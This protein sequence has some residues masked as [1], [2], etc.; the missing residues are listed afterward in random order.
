MS[1]EDKRKLRRRARRAQQNGYQEVCGFLAVGR[2]RTLPLVF[3]PNRA[4]KAGSFRIGSAD[5]QRVRK[6]LGKTRIVGTFHSHP[7]SPPAPSDSDIARARIGHYLMIHDVCGRVTLLWRIGR[8][9]GKKSANEIELRSTQ[10]TK[11]P[12]TPGLALKRVRNNKPRRQGRRPVH[13]GKA[14]TRGSARRR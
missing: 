6:A 9:D 5:E 11:K 1:P 2:H 4:T 8:I 12:E 10:R 13:D 14:N 3:V 7:V